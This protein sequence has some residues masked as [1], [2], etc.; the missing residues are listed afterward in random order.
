MNIIDLF[1]FTFLLY[2]HNPRVFTKPCYMNVMTNGYHKTVI[3]M[4]NK[5]WN[6]LENSDDF[7]FLLKYCSKYLCDRMIKEFWE[8]ITP[9]KF[10]WGLYSILSR[11]YSGLAYD[12]KDDVVTLGIDSFISKYS[13]CVN[14]D[15]IQ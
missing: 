4:N 15:D 10:C 6:P 14:S 2:K 3:Y 9:L 8:D 7:V 13:T 12:L 1:I 5:F 11:E